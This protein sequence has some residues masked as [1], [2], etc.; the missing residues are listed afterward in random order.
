MT[1]PARTL[2]DRTFVAPQI[3]LASLP[4][5]AAQ[6]VVSVMS[7]RPDGEDPGQPTAAEVQAAATEAGL[8]F[9]HAPVQ[10]FPDQTAVTATGE[11][12]ASLGP[13]DKV[14]MFCR[15]GTRSAVAWAL[16]MRAMGADA[17]DLRAAA[18]DAGYDLSRLPL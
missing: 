13:D 18:A 9:V 8:R 12:L 3:T 1:L 10:G 16:A 7:H 15:S 4:A 14:L 2:D 17:E 11:V 6:G 5:F